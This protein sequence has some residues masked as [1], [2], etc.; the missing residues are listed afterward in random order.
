M[1]RKLFLFLVALP[2]CGCWLVAFDARPRRETPRASP[3]PVAAERRYARIEITPDGIFHTDRQRRGVT[4]IADLDLAPPPPPLWILASCSPTKP[5]LASLAKLIDLSRDQGVFLN[6]IVAPSATI[7]PAPA[8]SPTPGDIAARAAPRIATVDHEGLVS[9]GV[10]RD[11]S[12]ERVPAARVREQLPESGCGASESVGLDSHGATS[13]QL[14]LA[15]GFF[16][17]AGCHVVFVSGPASG[18]APLPL[19]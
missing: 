8:P 3:T 2:L 16:A 6:A 14:V 1:I 19:Q 11:G 17:A 13:D 4:S 10:R 12:A 5:A 7:L 9:L 18:T 15:A